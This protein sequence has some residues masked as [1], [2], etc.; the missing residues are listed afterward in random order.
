MSQIKQGMS[1]CLDGLCFSITVHS[2]AFK[3]GCV[4]GALTK[5]CE[6]IDNTKPN[7]DT[8]ICVAWKLLTFVC[9]WMSNDTM[10]A[11]QQHANLI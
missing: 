8:L 7:I 11:L 9:F 10:A 6:G 3:V 2:I 1:V 5:C 4:A